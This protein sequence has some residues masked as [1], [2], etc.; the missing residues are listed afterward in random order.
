[1]PLQGCNVKSN[2]CDP[3]DPVSVTTRCISPPSLLICSGPTLLPP[4]TVQVTWTSMLGVAGST[5]CRRLCRG[6]RSMLRVPAWGSTPSPSLWR[7]LCGV[8][9]MQ[10][11]PWST[12]SSQVR[13]PS[14]KKQLG[15]KA[16]WMVGHFVHCQLTLVTW[17][18]C[19]SD[20]GTCKD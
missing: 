11:G 7:G 8:C 13:L 1:M 12:P 15:A 4:C 5:A 20:N 19:A 17:Q 18:L 14:T 3:L 9:C 16:P 6:W 10:R 2:L